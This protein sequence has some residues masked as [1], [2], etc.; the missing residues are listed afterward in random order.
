MFHA[1]YLKEMSNL[2][3]EQQQRYSRHLILK[4][5]GLEGQIKISKS[6]VLIIGAGGLGSP[7][8]L[9]LAA[10][11]VGTIGIVDRD[12]VSLSNLQRQII[13]YTEDVDQLKIESAARKM[14]AINPELQ[15]NSYNQFVEEETIRT[16]VKEYDFV[17]DA[18]DNFKTKFLINDACVSEKVPYSHGGV[19]GLK[20]QTMTVIPGKS[21]CYRCIFEEIPQTVDENNPAKVGVLGSVVGILG[22]T[23]ATETLKF[24]TNAGELLT[25]SLLNIN[26]LKME[27]QKL[28]VRKRKSC[29][30]C[31]Q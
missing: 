26:A 25:D 13:H 31:G 14:K 1:L 22:T 3:T 20:G 7:V 5:V 16:I 4:E 30:A 9:Y 23:Q 10:A 12:E 19:I 6:K 8:A 27:F 17:I 28:K 11:G 15:I 18:T 24:L 29:S 21:A 2:T